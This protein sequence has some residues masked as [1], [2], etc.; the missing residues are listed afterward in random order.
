MA[1]STQAVEPTAS[2]T[3][4][5]VDVVEVEVGA[6]GKPFDAARAQALIEKQRE[7]LKAAKAAAK[8]LAELKAA[9]AKR[10]DAELSEL[11]KE[12]KARLELESQLKAATLREMQR[13]AAEKAKLPAEFAD[14][15]RGETAEDMEADA[16]KLAAALPKQPTI[17]TD[18]TNPGN[19]ERSET[20]AEMRERL[21]PKSVN[22]F[23]PTFTRAQGGG[24]VIN[25]K[26]K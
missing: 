4:T 13:A 2:E 12:K 23:D 3:A 7:E 20:L 11:E 26:D 5:Q 10:K 15:I 18:P 6:D 25:D 8:E 24:L 14:R 16:A 1:D 21:M 17:K 19:A 9:E 22:I